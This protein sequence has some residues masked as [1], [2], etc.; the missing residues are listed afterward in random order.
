MAPTPQ[1]QV[2]PRPE[3][4]SGAFEPD[5]IGE[6][7]EKRYP[8]RVTRIGEMEIATGRVLLVD[9][10]L[11]STYDKPL[12]LSVRPGRYPVDL[13]VAD[14][15][16]GG[17]RV[18]LARL[19]L[20]P[21]PAVRWAMAVT[22]DQDAATLKGDEVFGYGVDAGTGAFVDAAVPAWLD[23]E[24]PTTNFDRFETLQDD[25]L[26]RGEA[27]AETIGIPYGFALI[28]RLGQ[29]DAAMFSSGW[30]DGHYASWIGYGSDD[31]AVAIVTDFAVITAANFP[32]TSDLR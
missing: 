10:F 28:E 7:A 15:G 9:P 19:L 21:A 26:K 17:H 4:L 24:Y 2:T 27:A 29:G 31:L 18:A 23:T 8:V 13:A 20:S 11:M 12:A 1:A 14:A 25:W 16:E 3:V 5:F 22:D 30:G 32:P 6:A